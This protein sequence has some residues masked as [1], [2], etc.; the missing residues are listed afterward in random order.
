LGEGLSI[1]MTNRKIPKPT[2]RELGIL[3]VLWE[4]GPS[5]VREVHE[6]LHEDSETGYT[7]TLKFMQIMAEKGLVVRDESK[8]THVYEAACSREETQNQLV[9]DLLEKAFGGSARH[10]VMSALSSKKP[11]KKEIEEIRRLLEN[12]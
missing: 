7:T 2:E 5:T 8:R 1:S 3:R 12:L 10:L 9:S 11:S 6:H 4:R